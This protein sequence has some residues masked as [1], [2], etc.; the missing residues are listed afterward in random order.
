[1]M[2]FISNANLSWSHQGSQRSGNTDEIQWGRMMVLELGCLGQPLVN[3][4]AGGSTPVDLCDFMVRPLRS[5]QGSYQD[6]PLGCENPRCWRCPRNQ[7]VLVPQV[8]VSNAWRHWG[9]PRRSVALETQDRSSR[10]FRP[11]KNTLLT[12]VSSKPS[13]TWLLA[14]VSKGY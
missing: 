1:M 11:R 10:E 8:A 5:L 2:V 6:F 9:P 14:M 13:P 12:M 3:E 7:H 4:E